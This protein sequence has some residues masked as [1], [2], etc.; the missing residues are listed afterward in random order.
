M[1]LHIESFVLSNSKIILNNFIHAING[2]NK[3]DLD[4][5]ETV[6]LNIENNY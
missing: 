6:C 2:F 1:P 3:I 4:H 5:T